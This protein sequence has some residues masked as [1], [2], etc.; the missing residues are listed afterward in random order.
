MNTATTYIAEL[1]IITNKI[2]GLAKLLLKLIQCCTEIYCAFIFP[3]VFEL[4]TQNTVQNTSFFSL[5][6][7]K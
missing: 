4:N 5:Q 3:L 1:N 7:Y 2:Q 6:L